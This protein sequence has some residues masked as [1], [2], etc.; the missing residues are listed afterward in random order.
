MQQSL[1][2]LRIDLI[3]INIFTLDYFSQFLVISLF[4]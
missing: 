2:T 3:Y 1:A 4:D